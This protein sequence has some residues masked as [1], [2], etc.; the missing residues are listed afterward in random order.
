MTPSHR[1]IYNAAIKRRAIFHTVLTSNLAAEHEISVRKCVRSWRQ[2][3]EKLFACAG[4]R[5]SL[6][7]EGRQEEVIQEEV[8]KW[9]KEQRDK[10]PSVSYED[11]QVKARS[12]ANGLKIASSDFKMSKKWVT[13]LS[14]NGPSLGRCTTVR[15]SHLMNM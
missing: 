5:K 14:Q 7:P 2:Q 9:V 3:R 6:G 10:S 1:R 15:R 8:K 4:S 12:V 11:I 13:N